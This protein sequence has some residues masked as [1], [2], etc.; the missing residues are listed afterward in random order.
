MRKFVAEHRFGVL[1]ALVATAAAL[2]CSSDGTATSTESDPN[3]GGGGLGGLN[4]AAGGK[5]GSDGGRMAAG[6]GTG[7]RDGT[8]A[9]GSGAG[10]SPVGGRAAMSG[11]ASSMQ[12]GRSGM[13][14][15]G[16]GGE[17]SGG[18]AALG[19]ASGSLNGAGAGAGGGSAGQAGRG[20]TSGNGNAG[21]SG[22]DCNTPP[23]P[24]ALV[25][26]ASEGSGTSGGGDAA[27]IVVT[28]AAELT[29]NL[30]GS[31]ARVIH[32]KG[33]INGSFSVGSN[34]TIVGVCAAEIHGHL[35]ISNQSNVI[36]RNLKMV[37]YNCSDSP[38]E[39]KSGADAITVNSGSHHLWFDHLDVS[40]GSDGNLDI[41]QGSD[42]VSVSF[43]KFHYSSKR[44]DPEA[45]ASGHRFSNLIGASDTDAA[46][47]GHLNVTFHH[48]WWADNVDQRMPRTRR[49]QIHVFNNLFTASG[50][51]YCTNA[52]Q[53]AKLLVQNNLY[54]GVNNP[55][56]LANNGIMKEEG[57]VFT[58][59]TG[60]QTGSGAGFTPPY[61]FTL[62][63]TAG[64]EAAV[65]AAAGPH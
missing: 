46:D 45:G 35:S 53:D 8:G 1:G 48:C 42:F 32:V 17:S 57:N 52:G 26:W 43:T 9:R 18:A 63:A 6:V 13:L 25:G 64:L 23:A 40:D 33:S 11:G 29:Q 31:T 60:D 61:A 4:A 65:R 27:P 7:G 12:A 24:S 28:T 55:F 47:P 19:G 30:S 41:T 50:N 56:Q 14:G 20:G 38:N 39:C 34:K 54:S 3:G 10:E 58:N 51:S 44:S 49:G 36:V 22:G 2:G 15:G 16:S 21:T 59:T 5:G 62:D 37:G